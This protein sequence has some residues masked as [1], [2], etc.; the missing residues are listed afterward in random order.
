MADLGTLLQQLNIAL[1]SY[2]TLHIRRAAERTAAA[3]ERIA[4]AVET[5]RE[6]APWGDVPPDPHFRSPGLLRRRE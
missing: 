4:T 6:A 5:P 3:T 1:I 2:D